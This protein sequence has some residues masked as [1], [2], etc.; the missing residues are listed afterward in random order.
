MIDHPIERVLPN[1]E[2]VRPNGDRSWMACCPA[3]EDRTPSLSISAGDDGRVLLNCFA[4]C[5]V[6]AVLAALG[7]ELSDLYV[8]P[9]ED[10]RRGTLASQA[11]HKPPRDE[12]TPRAFVSLDDVRAAYVGS[13]G[14]P[15]ASWTYRDPAGEVLG[16]VFR[17]ETPNGK[18]IRPAF[19]VGDGWRQTYPP[20][21]P[22]YGLERIAGEDRVFVVEGEKAAERLHALGFPAVTSAGGSKAAGR[23]DWSTLTASEVIVIPDADDAGE[24]YVEAVTDLLAAPSRDVVI[25]RLPGLRPRSGDDV[26]EW[27]A[28]VHNDDEDAAK[29]SLQAIGAEAVWS[30]RRRQPVLTIAEVLD[31]PAWRRPPEVIRTGVAWY[32]DVQP[33]GGIERGTLTVL[34]APPRCF[35]TALMLNLGWHLAQN[36]YRVH[37]L[38]GEMTRP[39]LVR[40]IVAMAAEVSPAVVAEPRVGREAERVAAAVA[41]VHDLG[42]RLVLGRA[43]ITLGGIAKAAETAD[44]V[45][46]D[47]LQLIQPDPDHAGSGRVDELDAAM[48]SLLALTQ[49]GATVVAAAALNRVGRDTVSLGSIRGSSA[50]EYGATTVYGTNELLAGI[51]PTADGSPSKRVSVK[52]ACLKQRE[53]EPRPLRFDVALE[54][55]PLPLDPSA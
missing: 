12:P 45:F 13:L 5:G 49:Q 20:V 26:V 11:F 10:A 3:H 29:Q 55:G 6:E 43:P 17:W 8:T 22:L 42:D 38:A 21:R 52:Y 32:D 54:L 27:I 35:K 1:L 51:D 18:T 14:E 48:R 41:R 31:D 24:A 30:V 2:K 47:Y 7:L 15:S 9:A 28:E 16:V 46:V 34:A 37:Y 4:G 25:L 44:I 50:I 19:R 39:A 23:A 40:R 53:G 36:G 33:F